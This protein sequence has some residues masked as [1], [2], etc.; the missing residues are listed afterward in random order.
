MGR[1]VAEPGWEKQGVCSGIHWTQFFASEE[2]GGPTSADLAFTIVDLCEKCPVKLVC[3]A[4]ALR[5]ELA[6]HQ[7][8]SYGV[9]GGALPG[10]RS[11]R[12]VDI[13]AERRLEAA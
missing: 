7:S 1:L 4:E 12:L 11:K 2:D 8:V 13:R 9:R 10:D 3:G 6:T 5:E